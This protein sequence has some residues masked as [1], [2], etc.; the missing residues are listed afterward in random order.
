MYW[1]EAIRHRRAISALQRDHERYANDMNEKIRAAEKAKDRDTYDALV[2]DYLNEGDLFENEVARRE[3][4]FLVKEA[5]RYM[6]PVPP[7]KEGERWEKSNVD[8]RLYLTF[9]AMRDLRNGIREERRLRAEPVTIWL[10]L[11][12]GLVGAITGLVSVL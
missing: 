6:I 3:T 11:A 4:R 12:I 9:A 10:P 7:A 2:S 5:R 1:L 8:E